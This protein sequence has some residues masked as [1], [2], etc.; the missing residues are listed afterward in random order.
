[1]Y[2]FKTNINSVYQIFWITHDLIE[3]CPDI[4]LEFKKKR[5]CTIVF[6][7]NTGIEYPQIQEIFIQNQ[8]IYEN[9]IKYNCIK[10]II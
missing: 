7:S 8:I 2:V 6:I 1:M 4:N 3:V 9:V 10:K 5:K